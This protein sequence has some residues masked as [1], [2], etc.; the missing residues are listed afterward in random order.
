MCRPRARP[1]AACCNGDGRSCKPAH[2]AANNAARRGSSRPGRRAK[3]KW[4]TA[5]VQLWQAQPHWLLYGDATQANTINRLCGGAE[6]PGLLVTDSP[7]GVEY[8]AAW[9]DAVD[10]KVAPSNRGKV[11]GDDRVNWSTVFAASISRD[12]AAKILANCKIT[13]DRCTSPVQLV[14]QTLCVL[15]IL[16]AETLS[17]TVRKYPRAFRVT[18]IVRLISRNRR[19]T[20]FPTTC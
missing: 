5:E 3:K 6:T 8:G 13:S 11:K 10:G 16:R 18:V 9:R 20:P 1:S 12:R 15:L 19:P 2:R 7:Y 17:E 4:G 14:E